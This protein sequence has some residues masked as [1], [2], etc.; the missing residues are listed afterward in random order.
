MPGEKF[1]LAAV[2]WYTRINVSFQVVD[3]R[4]GTEI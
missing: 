1:A 4:D 3:V 2:L